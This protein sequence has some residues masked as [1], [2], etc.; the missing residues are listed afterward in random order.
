MSSVT[1]LSPSFQGKDWATK[2]NPQLVLGRKAISLRPAPMNP[3]TFSR[4]A[5]IAAYQ[6]RQSAAPRSRAF[7]LWAAMASATRRGRGATEAWLK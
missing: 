4:A 5:S 1:T 2:F 3:A 6:R 7:S